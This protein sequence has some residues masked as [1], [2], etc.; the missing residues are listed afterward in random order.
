MKVSKHCIGLG[1]AT[2]VAVMHF[3]TLKPICHEVTGTGLNNIFDISFEGLT[4]AY[5]CQTRGMI[6][7]HN[8]TQMA[9]NQARRKESMSAISDAPKSQYTAIV[10][11][12]I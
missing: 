5:Q 1:G 12:K 2:E 11:K 3:P 7:V 10:K 8:F 4:L 9:T 6:I